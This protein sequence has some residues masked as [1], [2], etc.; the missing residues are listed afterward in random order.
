[1]PAIPDPGRP[2]L[3]VEIAENQDVVVVR[4]RAREQSQRAGFSLLE[5]TKL[6]VETVAEM[7]GYGST[8]VLRERKDGSENAQLVMARCTLLGKPGCREWRR[9]SACRPSYAAYLYA[10]ASDG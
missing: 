4:Q 9:A 2:V 1:M 5:T 8:T 3:R 6:S 10:S 7:V